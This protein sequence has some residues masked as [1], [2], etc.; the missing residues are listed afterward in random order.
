MEQSNSN[1]FTRVCRYLGRRLASFLT[2][3]SA[4]PSHYPASDPDRLRAA[5]RPCDVLLVEGTAR[6]STAIKYLTQS[7]W[8]HAAIYVGD[9]LGRDGNGASLCFVEADA[10][11]GIRAVSLREFDGLHTR[12]C[13]PIGLTREDSERIVAF[14]IARIGDRYDLKNL[15]DLA[16]Y[17]FPTPPVPVAWRR[18]M[19]ALGSGDPTRALCST[20]LAQ[21]FEV[22]GFPI[23]PEISTEML[24]DPDCRNCM[25]EILHIRHHSLFVP[26][27]FDVSPYF[28][29]IKPT[30]PS[31]WDYRQLEWAHETPESALPETHPDDLPAVSP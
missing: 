4:V 10:V 7:T 28:T 13:R 5:L 2:D 12:I 23:L 31:G 29:I 18:Q 16:R 22:V 17:L 1:P 21:A 11:A 9:A 14:V 25:R 3:P 15:F 8:S 6:I 24:D 27:D 20:L 19:I 30:V 26:R